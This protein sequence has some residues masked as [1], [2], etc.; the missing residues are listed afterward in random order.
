MLV[1]KILRGV[2]VQQKWKAH[3]NDLNHKNKNWRYKIGTIR[4]K[5]TLWGSYIIRN[6]DKKVY[7]QVKNTFAGLTVDNRRNGEN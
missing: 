5:I 2:S 6:G 3:G 7:K 4:A 1:H